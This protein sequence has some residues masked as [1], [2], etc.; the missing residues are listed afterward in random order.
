MLIN[1]EVRKYFGNVRV[2][3]GKYKNLTNLPHWHS[4]NELV[5]A[6]KGNANL[7]ID[8][9]TF[10][11]NEGQSVYIAPNCMHYIKA[12]NGSILTFFLFDKDISTKIVGNK[13]LISPLLTNDYNLKQLYSLIDKELT[14]SSPIYTISITNRIERL[15][16][17]IFINEAVS[18]VLVQ[19]DYLTER[20]KRLLTDINENYAEY[21][22]EDAA[23]FT[24]LSESYFSKFFKKMSG[25]TFTQY[26]NLVRVE[27]AIEK[28]RSGGSTMTD[29]AIS[30]GFVT[31]RN[32]N[33]VFKTITGYSPRE[34]PTTYDT[35]NMHPVYGIESSFD[36]TSESSELL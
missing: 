6:E 14:L 18:E 17:D 30:C 21:S 32:F 31:I 1:R 10:L 12:E 19:D 3:V 5:F 28:I 9:K 33:R 2:W 29:I 8:G 34:L 22:I 24:A 7:F 27:K 20:Y 35:L 11:L 16:L 23:K 13:A 36:P 15:M 26:I 25:M 4:D